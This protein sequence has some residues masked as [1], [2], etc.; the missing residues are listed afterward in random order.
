MQVPT[1]A[2]GQVQPNLSLPPPLPTPNPTDSVVGRGLIGQDQDI[3]PG[4]KKRCIWGFSGLGWF[5]RAKFSEQQLK[6]RKEKKKKVIPSGAIFLN[7]K[8]K[9]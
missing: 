8:D 3:D 4:G 9:A 2:P 6:K 7:P 1:V 5:G